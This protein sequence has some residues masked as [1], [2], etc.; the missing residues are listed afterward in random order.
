MGFGRGDVNTI[1]DSLGVTV[2]EDARENAVTQLMKLHG[3]TISGMKQRLDS[4][5]AMD[6][7]GLKRDSEALQGIRKKLGNVSIDDALATHLSVT[8]QLGDRKLADVLRENSEYAAAALNEKKTKAVDALLTDYKFTSKAAETFIRGELSALELR[9]DGGLNN[10]EAKLKELVEANADAIVS[11]KQEQK[12]RFSSGQ[13]ASIAQN[14]MTEQEAYLA[15][16][17]KR[18]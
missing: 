9:K 12:P 13:H 5:D 17:K 6:I 14:T 8:E 10:G 16:L 2:P 18:V 11:V 3:T 15:R 7:D 1:I 4:Y